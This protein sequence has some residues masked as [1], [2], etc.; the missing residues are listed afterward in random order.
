MIK[1]KNSKKHTITVLITTILLGL[2]TIIFNTLVIWALW[3]LLVSALF[4]MAVISGTIVSNISI[5]H[6]LLLYITINFIKKL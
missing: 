6:A 2:L 4:P 1:I 3:G 5:L